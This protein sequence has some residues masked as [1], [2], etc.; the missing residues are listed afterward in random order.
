MSSRLL[1][2]PQ[3]GPLLIWFFV[4]NVAI[5]NQPSTT[6]IFTASDHGA[7]SLL[8]HSV[9]V[10]RNLYH[11]S[12]T[13]MST[14]ASRPADDVC[15]G[16]LK[17]R[18][19]LA[20]SPEISPL[21]ARHTTRPVMPE[22]PF[23]SWGFDEV[24]R[25]PAI[26]CC[27]VLFLSA[28]ICSAG[29]IGGGGIYVTVLMVAGELSPHDAVPLSKA[30][31]FFGSVSSLVLN[32][33]KSLAMQQDGQNQTLIDYNVCRLIVPC[34]LL[35]TLIGVMV[36]SLIAPQMIVALLVF[37][38]SVMTFMSV[39]KFMNQRMEETGAEEPTP[40]SGKRQDTSSESSEI[41][42]DGSI[43]GIL[44]RGEGF[45]A[46]FLL[47]FSVLCGVF[48]QHSERCR[49]LISGTLAHEVKGLSLDSC[50]RPIMTFFFGGSFCS[51][52]AH[53]TLKQLLPALAMVIPACVC[54]LITLAYSRRLVTHEGWHPKQVVSYTVMAL[55]TG[56]FAGLVGIGGGLVFCPFML[57]SGL[58]PAVAVA[59]SSTCVIFTSSSTTMQYL[60]TDR[61]ILSLALLY[62]VCSAVGSYVG[63]SGVHMLQEKFHAQ[64]SYISGIVCVGV[65]GSVVLSVYKLCIIGISH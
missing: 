52:M 6:V 50:A 30:V 27:V 63:T 55:L 14:L 21:Q 36:N 61:I 25:T 57:W 7:V 44:L 53:P 34:C 10:D 19:S 2:A 64:Q 11:K 8:Q 45:G 48:R 15:S 9:N 17:P 20:V 22:H 3:H 62:G 39:S 32:V 1:G 23:P 4:T 54:L 13:G 56:C 60:L 24:K 43:R 41:Q 31:V 58:H 29:G 49:S 65:L 16:M 42:K 40:T 51:W 12:E 33:K 26:I 59:T 35:G 37:I 38:L 5:V 46:F 18:L 47:V 28:V